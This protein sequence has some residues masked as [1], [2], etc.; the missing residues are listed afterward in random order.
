MKSTLAVCPEADQQGDRRE[1]G[2][3]GELTRPDRQVVEISDHFDHVL[4]PVD[5]AGDF[6]NEKDDRVENEVHHGGS[7]SEL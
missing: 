5:D 1:T 7:P 2:Q 3:S 6:V 4:Q